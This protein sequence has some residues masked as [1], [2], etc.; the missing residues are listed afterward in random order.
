MAKTS[1]YKPGSAAVSASVSVSGDHRPNSGLR[2][3]DVS[4]TEVNEE[5]RR[6]GKT[7]LFGMQN[8]LRN[9][10]LMENDR[11]LPRFPAGSPLLEFFYR[12]VK[13][14]PKYLIKAILHYDISVTMVGGKNLLVF[15]EVTTYGRSEERRQ[16]QESGQDLLAFHDVRYHQSFHIGFTRKTIYI[17]EGMIREAIFEG[18]NTWV[19]SEMLVRETWP[20]LDYLL[21]LDFVRGAQKHFKTHHTLGSPQVARKMLDFANHHMVVRKDGKEGDLDFFFLHYCN[22]L[23]ELN[24]DIV[25]ADPHEVVDTFFDENQESIWAENKLT[26][27]AGLYN[28][29]TSFNVDRDMIH[30]VAIRAAELKGVSIEPQNVDEMLHDLKDVARF[31]DRHQAKSGPLLDQLVLEGEEGIMGFSRA[32]AREYATGQTYITY[33]SSRE[34]GGAYNAVDQFRRRLQALSNGPKDGMSD[35]ISKDFRDLLQYHVLRETANQVETFKKL[36]AWSQEANLNYLKRLLFRIVRFATQGKEGFQETLIS[37]IQTATEV[38]PLLKLAQ[39]YR[40]A[41]PEEL[42]F[43]LTCIF[44]RLDKDEN[45]SNLVAEI[46]TFGAEAIPAL[47]FTLES[48]LEENEAC[49]TIRKTAQDLINVL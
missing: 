1:F 10:L 26:Q 33:M 30:P 49:Q 13:K 38:R 22:P 28:F 2:E 37:T 40:E 11:I 29:P 48:I 18:Y 5:L 36:P 43:N 15:D 47:E 9:G 12:G 25:G 19:I 35:S 39:E 21:L 31:K 20:L 16:A 3:G 7:V 6:L 4:H 17:P 8:R 44:I 42:I 27:I 24:R 34:A 46:R 14:L 32:I 23:L 45:Y 41:A